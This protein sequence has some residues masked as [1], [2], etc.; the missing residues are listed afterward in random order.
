MIYQTSRRNIEV[1]RQRFCRKSSSSSDDSDYVERTSAT[2]T[3]K[4]R[5]KPTAKNKQRRGNDRRTQLIRKQ[6]TVDSSQDSAAA[7]TRIEQK[8]Y[9]ESE[10]RRKS[11]LEN[12]NDANEKELDD[13]MIKLERKRPMCWNFVS[14]RLSQ[15]HV[16]KLSKPIVESLLKNNTVG[17]RYSELQN[18]VE[19]MFSLYKEIVSTVAEDV[20][21]DRKARLI[22][23]W[24]DATTSYLD[25]IS[26]VS[27]KI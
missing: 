17:A 5:R 24:M 2:K 7:S 11:K 23:R 16:M 12:N 6:P 4:E 26:T 14:E 18:L 22:L 15:Q 19:H 10:P 8:H 20:K 25:S 21:K 27:P 13:A 1:R 9:Q 3:V